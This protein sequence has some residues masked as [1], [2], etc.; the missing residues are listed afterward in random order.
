MSE[1]GVVGMI[2]T[3]PGCDQPGPSLCASCRLVGYC[4][5][6]CQVEDWTRHKETDCQRHLRKIG[7][8]HLQKARGF[9]RD[10]NWL[11]TLRYSELALVKLKQ[12]ND[13]PIEDIDEALRF[14][15]NALNLMARNREALECA[16]ERYCLYLTCHTHP[17]AIEASFALIESCIHNEEYEDAELYART[18]WET[19]TLSR[20]SH[21]PDNKR[22]EF[23]AQGA[24]YLAKAMLHLAQHGDIPPEANQTV[25]QEA[26]GLARRAV[27]IYAKLD[28][29]EHIHVANTMLVLADTLDY[30]NNVDD[31]EVLR[32]Y[33]Q[34]NSIFGRVEGRLSVNV[35]VG[36]KNLAM[37]YHNS[38]RRARAANE[39][40]REM[41]NLESELTHLREAARIYRAANHMASADR[42]AQLIV[43]VEEK[44]RQC[45]AASAAAAAA[46]RG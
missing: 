9:D 34:S 4:C 2:C 42:V 41:A 28:G 40:D 30:F 1:A 37:V 44:M 14:K 46:T 19:I 7:M 18:T 3:R 31:V 8:A 16:Q 38:A 5:R 32:L 6:T 22:Q 13:R 20:D 39:L 21:I 36:E 45:T 24:H 11:Q 10:N 29:L 33:E 15:F 26:I 23:T 17:P 27:E 12:L 43:D 25:G 35:A